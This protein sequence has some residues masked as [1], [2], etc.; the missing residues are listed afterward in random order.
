MGSDCACM[1]PQ[2]MSTDAGCKSPFLFMCEKCVVTEYESREKFA[3]SD[4][5]GQCSFPTQLLCT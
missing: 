5:P 1:G 3:G 2:Y 4:M